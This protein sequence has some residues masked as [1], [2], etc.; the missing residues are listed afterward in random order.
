MRLL[1]GGT[2]TGHMVLA[3]LLCVGGI[4]LLDLAWELLAQKLLAQRPPDLTTAESFDHFMRVS[5]WGWWLERGGLTLLWLLALMVAFPRGLVRDEY[6]TLLAFELAFTV[7]RSLSGRG[8]GFTTDFLF[9]NLI[10]GGVAL[11]IHYLLVRAD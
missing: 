4:V 8:E 1:A 10:C 7:G 5:R 6:P 3:L 11:A 2:Q 9:M